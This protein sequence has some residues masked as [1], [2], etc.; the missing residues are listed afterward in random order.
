MF[1]RMVGHEQL[2]RPGARSREPAISTPCQV[3]VW[4]GRGGGS[5]GGGGGGS[6][7]GGGDGGGGDNDGGG[8]MM[9]VVTAGAAQAAAVAKVV[10]MSE[11][12]LDGTATAD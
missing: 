4:P 5:G 10:E 9:V 3:W 7:G 11:S 12:E 1:A 2:G 6:G 8:C